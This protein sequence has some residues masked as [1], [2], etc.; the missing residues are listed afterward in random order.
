[1][2]VRSCVRAF[3]AIVCS[4]S[5]AP[6]AAE[7][8]ATPAAATP[9]RVGPRRAEDGWLVPP[10]DRLMLSSLQVLRVN[11]IGLENQ[12]RF[13]W[14][15]RLYED[16]GRAFRDNFFFLGLFPKLNP[17]YSRIGPGLE[18]Q[19]ASFFHL[20]MTAIY[21][22]FLHSFGFVQSTE[23]TAADYSDSARKAGDERDESYATN[24]G[25]FTIEPMLQ[26]KVGSFAARDK[27]SAEYWVAD[28]HGE[29]EFFFEGTLDTLVPKEGWVL[30]NDA[31]LLWIEGDGLVLG[32]RHTL[33]APQYEDGAENGHHRLGVL[34]AYTLWEDGFTRFDKPTILGIV[35]WYLD[36][37]YRTGVDVPRAMPYVLLGFAFTTDLL[38]P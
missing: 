34:A 13:G 6:A 10:A 3:A 11:P 23:T 19:P 14:Q 24:A 22:R 16:E 18:L 4:L 29:D 5:A 8:P 35:S 26:L 1:M 30:Q 21:V 28:L 25:Q 9:A 7:E 31:D 27:L 33:V 37:P 17:A 2:S 12:L 32:L 36:H 38:E 15:H 20:R